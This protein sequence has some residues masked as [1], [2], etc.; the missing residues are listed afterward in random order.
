[1][2][3][4]V[5]DFGA[6]ARSLCLGRGVDAET[7]VVAHLVGPGGESLP[8]LPISVAFDRIDGPSRGNRL[9][10]TANTDERGRF[11]ACSVPAGETVTLR[12]YVGG[13]WVDLT[14]FAA[15]AGELTYRE[16]RFGR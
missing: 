7:I 15:P 9:T 2:E 5:P 8:G 6:A 3:L 13:E 4:E 1:V 12:S 16:V 10:L 11:A 14:E